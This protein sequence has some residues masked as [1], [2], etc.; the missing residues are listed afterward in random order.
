LQLVV[1][2]EPE[3]G[4]PAPGADGDSEDDEVVDVHALEDA[5]DVAGSGV[6]RLAE[7]FPGAQLIEEET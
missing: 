1:D 3:G 2:T 5:P 6:D 7:A 4:L